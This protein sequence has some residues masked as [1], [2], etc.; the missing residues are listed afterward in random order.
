MKNPF[1]RKNP[2]A[3]FCYVANIDLSQF[4]LGYFSSFIPGL[5]QNYPIIRSW[6]SVLCLIFLIG[7]T[8]GSKDIVTDEN[9]GS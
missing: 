4:L 2:I 7:A 1:Y 8:S 6:S 9:L 5:G 3:L